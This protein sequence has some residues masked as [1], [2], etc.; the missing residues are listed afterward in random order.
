M[1]LNP[2][3]ALQI[4]PTGFTLVVA[5]TSR[6]KPDLPGRFQPFEDCMSIREMLEIEPTQHR[7]YVDSALAN[8]TLS[9][10]WFNVFMAKAAKSRVHRIILRDLW[11]KNIHGPDEVARWLQQAFGVSADELDVSFRTFCRTGELPT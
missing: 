3:S 1:A 8:M 10:S 11:R 6:V 2:W 7:S 9:A 5:Y 4:R